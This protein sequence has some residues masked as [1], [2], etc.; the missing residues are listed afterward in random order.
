METTDLTIQ[1]LTDI[2][3]EIRSTNNRIDQTNVELRSTRE[4]LRT[5]LRTGLER[6]E[7]RVVESEIRLATG[8]TEMSGTLRDVRDMLAGQLDLRDRV[9]RC[10]ADIADLKRRVP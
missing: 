3:D 2:R 7:K 9:E 5:E 1:I 4:E 8:I 6:V 10:E